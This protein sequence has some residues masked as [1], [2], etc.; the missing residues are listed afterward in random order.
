MD[1]PR[2]LRVQPHT[3]LS[4]YASRSCQCS[5]RL[6]RRLTSDYPIIGEP[7][8]LISFASHLLIERRQKNVTEQWRTYSSYTI[9]NFEFERKV[10]FERRTWYRK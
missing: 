10:R 9:D 3:Q 4:Q 1:N 8:Q 6:S 2:L 5:T 7:R